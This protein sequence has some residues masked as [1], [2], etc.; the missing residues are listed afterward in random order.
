MSLSSLPVYWHG[1]VISALTPDL[2]RAVCE[3]ALVFGVAAAAL[4]FLPDFD[5]PV[6]GSRALK[7]RR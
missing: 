6:R 7:V 2:A 5:E 1:V 3:I 4:S